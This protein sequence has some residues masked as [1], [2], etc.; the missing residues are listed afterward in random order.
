MNYKLCLYL[1]FILFYVNSFTQNNQVLYDFDQLPQTLLLNPGAEVD[2]DKHFG[3]P[4]LSN[5][6]FE[7]GA[8]NRD[9]NYNNVLAPSNSVDDVLRNVYDLSSS[10]SDIFLIN[11]RMEILS[12]GFRL[13][14]PKYYLSFG[15]YQETEGFA[16]YPVDLAN[17]YFNGDD[18]AGD[19]SPEYGNPFSF[20]PLNFVGELVGVF[21]IGISKKVNKN[22]TIGA[23]VKLLSGSLNLNTKNNSGEYDLSSSIF[24][25]HH[26]FNDMNLIIN[27]SGF[28]N[29]EELIIRFISLKL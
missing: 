11:Q 19:G 9:I 14:D 25:N 7:I 15:M 13:K 21:H 20:T 4:F 22:L 24:G 2:Y 16:N 17:L 27:S 23:R 6:Y 10:N 12:A 1:P 26:N 29:P 28:I 18:Q 3:V 8:S 5:V